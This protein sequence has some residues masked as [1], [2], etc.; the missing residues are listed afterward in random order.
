M[1]RKVIIINRLSVLQFPKINIFPLLA[2][3]FLCEKFEYKILQELLHLEMLLYLWNY[4]IIMGDNF[5]RFD[6]VSTD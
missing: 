1:A 2:G 4:V 3:N 5:S 6:Q